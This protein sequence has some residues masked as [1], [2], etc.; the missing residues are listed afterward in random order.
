MCNLI[1]CYVDMLVYFAWIVAQLPDKRPRFIAVVRPV[2]VLISVCH[3][4][5]CSTVS[6]CASSYPAVTVYA[7]KGFCS[8]NCMY[9]LYCSASGGSD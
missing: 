4:F 3:V 1:W 2:S 8:Y 9:S 5:R 7:A 6:A